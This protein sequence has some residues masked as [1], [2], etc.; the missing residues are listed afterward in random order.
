MPPDP[1]ARRRALATVGVMAFGRRD[2]G[3]AEAAQRQLVREAKA[4]YEPVETALGLYNLGNTLIA[5]GRAEEAVEVLSHAADGCC[6]HE[7]DQLAPMVYTNLGIALHRAGTVDQAFSSLKVARD[8]FQAQGNL[9]AEAHVCDCLAILHLEQG[10]R[11]DAEKAWRYAIELYDRITNPAMQDVRRGG[12]ADIL[13]KL[14][15]LERVDVG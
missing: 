14:D 6:Y 4:A 2:Y 9:P 3:K 10:R 13:V 11:P 5:A 15:R 12:R 1:A 7:L 8:M